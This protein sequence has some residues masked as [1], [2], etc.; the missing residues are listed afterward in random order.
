MR[1]PLYSGVEGRL[2][3]EAVAIVA[4]RGRVDMRLV[5]EKGQRK[6]RIRPS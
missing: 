2:G 5:E 1:R 6:L 3:E 4:E